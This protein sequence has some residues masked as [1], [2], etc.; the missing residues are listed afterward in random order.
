MKFNYA[1]LDVLRAN[2]VLSYLGKHICK[3]SS[4]IDREVEATFVH[5]TSLWYYAK[6]SALNSA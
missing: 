3:G 5:T 6:Y 4:T 1:D 2:L